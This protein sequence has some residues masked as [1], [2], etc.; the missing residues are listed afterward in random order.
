M[1]RLSVGRITARSA[2][3]KD[4][5]STGSLAQTFLRKAAALS[6]NLVAAAWWFFNTVFNHLISSFYS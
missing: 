5:T 4:A 6:A 2:R 1:Y 3:A